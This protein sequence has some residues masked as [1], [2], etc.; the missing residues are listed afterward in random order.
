MG[1]KLKFRILNQ[2]KLYGAAAVSG[3]KSFKFRS[4]SKE[5]QLARE[6]YVCYDDNNNYNNKRSLNLTLN[7]LIK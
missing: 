7:R 3:T 6:L 1:K 4:F 5:L 2:L